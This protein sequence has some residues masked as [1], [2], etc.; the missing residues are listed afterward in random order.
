MLGYFSE[1]ADYQYGAVFASP[2][3]IT[4]SADLTQRFVRAYQKGNADYASAFL[5]QNDKG[6]AVVDEATG[7]AAALIGKYVYP[8]DAAEKAAPA[9]IA[10]SVYVDAKAALDPA[11]IGRQVAWYKSEKLVGEKVD[12]KDFVVTDFTR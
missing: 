5:R 8:G 2:K 1:V 10:A 4:D 6:E 7:A 11:E 12:V 9:I 3:T